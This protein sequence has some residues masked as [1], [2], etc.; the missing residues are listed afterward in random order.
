MTICAALLFAGAWAFKSTPSASK[1]ISTSFDTISACPPFKVAMYASQT[2][3]D[4]G[5]LG[6]RRFRR[7][8]LLPGTR[9]Q[10]ILKEQGNG[11]R[12]GSSIGK[13][14]NGQMEPGNNPSLRVVN[15][16]G[17]KDLK[18]YLAQ[19]VSKRG[20]GRRGANPVC[21]LSE[22]AGE[23]ARTTR[24][25]RKSGARGPPRGLSSPESR[26]NHGM[27]LID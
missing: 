12:P 1:R 2:T 11:R 9:P 17:V 10:A 18:R 25:S 6:R 16:Q 13:G 26:I 20:R 14:V 24:D 22:D 23:I 8:G 5:S 4:A 3:I 15:L 21:S 7:D 19:F 27:S